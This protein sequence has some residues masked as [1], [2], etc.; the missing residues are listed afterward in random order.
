MFRYKP[1]TIAMISTI[2]IASAALI[3][4]GVIIINPV[5]DANAQAP[6]VIPQLV[7]TDDQNTVTI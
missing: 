7:K 5:I 6:G 1:T 2:I 3:G 4:L